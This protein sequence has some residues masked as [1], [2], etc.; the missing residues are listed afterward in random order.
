MLR[1]N[2]NAFHVDVPAEY[3]ILGETG[4]FSGSLDGCPYDAPR[5]LSA[6]EHTIA[7]ARQDH[8]AIVWSR[9]A[10]KGF[11]P[12]GVVERTRQACKPSLVRALA[13]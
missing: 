1:P 8:Y 3:A 11:S 6:G 9:A 13:R 4:P 2:R 12:F 5:F 7:P 10:A